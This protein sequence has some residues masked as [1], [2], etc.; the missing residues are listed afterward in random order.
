MKTKPPRYLYIQDVDD[1]YFYGHLS[2]EEAGEVYEKE[3]MG[4]AIEL[5]ESTAKVLHTIMRFVPD[6]T[7][8]YDTKLIDSEP[9]RGAFPV[10]VVY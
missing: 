4:K 9:G 8:D 3:G 7:G 5:T 10:T 2:L 6:F 1:H